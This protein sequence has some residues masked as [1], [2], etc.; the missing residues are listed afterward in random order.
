MSLIKTSY[1][2]TEE[3]IDSMLSR[4]EPTDRT[5]VEK[6]FAYREEK[7]KKSRKGFP[8]TTKKAIIDRVAKLKANGQ[9]IEDCVN[10]SIENNW[11][12]L[13]PCKYGRVIT[14]SIISRAN[15]KDELSPT[16][17]NILDSLFLRGQFTKSEAIFITKILLFIDEK[18]ALNRLILQR[19]EIKAPTIRFIDTASFALCLRDSY[20]W[21]INEYAKKHN[22]DTFRLQD[23]VYNKMPLEIKVF[24]DV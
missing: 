15:V 13:F 1:V 21:G 2:C 5:S 4:L 11:V 19:L 16:K 10:Q 12:G 9:D 7:S 17:K 14:R 6:F 18:E 8:L 23:S 20:V 22:M 3:L 24:I